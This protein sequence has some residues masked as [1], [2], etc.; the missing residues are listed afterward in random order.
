MTK[1]NLMYIMI[2]ALVHVEYN[3]YSVLQ[4]P[5]VLCT[6]ELTP[7]MDSPPA[8]S[9]ADPGF[10]PAALPY[11]SRVWR[12]K[13][14]KV[15]IK[16]RHLLSRWRVDLGKFMECANRWSNGAVSEGSN[17]IPRFEMAIDNEEPDIVVELNGKLFE[18]SI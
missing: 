16:N 13:V 9:T 1:Q 7:K 8:A 3:Y 17:H 10:A 4:V 6:M 12:R 15:L 5:R 11:E 2:I 14:L 18:I